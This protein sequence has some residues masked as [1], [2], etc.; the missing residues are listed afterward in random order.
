MIGGFEIIVPFSTTTPNT[1]V[2]VA[3]EKLIT[4]W[5]DVYRR[6][7]PGFIPEDKLSFPKDQALYRFDFNLQRIQPV[8]SQ[9][10]GSKSRQP[11]LVAE[12]ID[13][14]TTAMLGQSITV[15]RI[16][17]N[18]GAINTGP[19]TLRYYLSA[20]RTITTADISIGEETFN[21]GLEAS[22]RS[23]QDFNLIIPNTVTPGTYYLGMIIDVNNN[24]A[25]SNE[26]NNTAADSQQI[27]VKNSGSTVIKIVSGQLTT[28]SSKFPSS[29]YYN[30][31]SV[32]LFA[33]QVL[34]MKL[35]SSA[36][37]SFE[38]LWNPRTRI[39]VTDTDAAV[40][41]GRSKSYSSISITQTGS[42]SIVVSSISPDVT[43]S[44]TFIVWA[45]PGPLDVSPAS[46][47]VAEIPQEQESIPSATRLIQNYPN[48]FNIETTIPFKVSE[49]A[50]VQ[51]RIYSIHGQLIRTLVNEPKE[52]GAYFA[53]WDGT[54][55]SGRP[56][57]SGSYL[58]KLR[59]GNS[60]EI[61][62]MIVVK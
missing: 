38:G 32:E 22:S 42:Y 31:H 51:L 10:P 21:S 61:K 12:L 40:P 62:K 28:S 54:D 30:R 5:S 37:I 53:Q 55:E 33:G 1:I 50:N 25:E 15:R 13:G 11:D 57:A 60:V 44:Y 49:R 52:K 36:N 4:E 58:Y 59:V 19:F 26:N 18:T 23:M 46:K 29:R 14:P 7:R 27:T 17:N 3:L 48:P 2:Q 41:K 20:D 45:T 35:I 43:G 24:V 9:R 39:Y 47:I 16:L 8:Q 6:G 56:V 34:S